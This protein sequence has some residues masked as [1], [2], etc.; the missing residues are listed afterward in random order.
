MTYLAVRHP[1]CNRGVFCLKGTNTPGWSESVRLASERKNRAEWRSCKDQCLKRI[2]FRPGIVCG[3]PQ[4]GQRFLLHF[5]SIG[6][7]ERI[8]IRDQLLKVKD[9]SAPLRSARD[10]VLFQG[11]MMTTHEQDDVLPSCSSPRV[12]P[13]GLLPAMRGS[14]YNRIT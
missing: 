1:E 12:P 4:G 2:F 11:R 10:D 7:V 14:I 5:S 3:S 6:K 13:R 9:P 8:R